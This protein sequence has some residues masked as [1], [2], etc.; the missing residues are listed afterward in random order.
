MQSTDR[1]TTC[2]LAF[3]THIG[4]LS[5]EE[6][7]EKNCSGIAVKIIKGKLAMIGL[8]TLVAALFFANASFAGDLLPIVFEESSIISSG[9]M[10]D[11]SQKR[12][13]PLSDGK[14]A[15]HVER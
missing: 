14:R 5:V 8:Y 4:L 9:K 13:G 10:T 2:K 7:T 15:I 12:P 11:F 1:K 3:R 6:R